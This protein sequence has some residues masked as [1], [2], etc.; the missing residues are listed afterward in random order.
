MSTILTNQANVA[1]NSGGQTNTAGSNTTVTTLLDQYGLTATKTALT[2]Q[3]RPGENIPYQVLITNNGQGPVYNVTVSDNL[4]GQTTP[5]PLTYVS[6]SGSL[7]QNGASTPVTPQQTSSGLSFTLPN[8]LAPGESVL[9][10]YVAQV[11][12]DWNENTSPITNTAAVSGNGGSTTG[13]VVNVTPSPTATITPED[14]ADLS[15]CKQADKDTVV[16]GDT[17]TYTMTL[18]NTGNSPAQNVVLTDTLPQGFQVNQV[19][20]VQNGVTTVV[21]PSDYTISSNNTITLPNSGATTTITVPAASDGVPGV[22]KVI[23]SGT[24]SSPT[25]A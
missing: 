25:T 11:R 19:S 2:S 15:L 8:P 5:P 21:P 22:T 18:T 3:Y 12:S 10:S 24:V 17:L 6:G 7:Y 9:L 13:P 14:Y 1:Y 23:V 4:G 20:L 16:S